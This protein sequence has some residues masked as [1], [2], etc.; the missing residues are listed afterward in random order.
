MKMFDKLVVST[1]ERRKAR[2]ARFFAGTVATY[3]VAVVAAF[4]LSV[5][6]SSPKLADTELLCKI[7]TPPPRIGGGS[8]PPERPRPVQTGAQRQDPNNVLRLDDV[9]QNLHGNPT[10]VT[11]PPVNVGASI[12]S[13]G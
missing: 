11:S 12:D 2:T 6:L 1:N 10:R 9:V 5:A 3:V 7:A 4:V 8:T 13:D